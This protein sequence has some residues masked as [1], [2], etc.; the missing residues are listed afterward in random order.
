MEHFQSRQWR[1]FC[2]DKSKVRKRKNRQ[3]DIEDRGTALK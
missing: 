3:E 2:G 1:L